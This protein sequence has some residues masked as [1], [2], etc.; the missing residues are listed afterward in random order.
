M[1]NTTLPALLPYAAKF[2]KE[3]DENVIPFWLKHSV[4]RKCGGY[5]SCLDR[6]GSVY[7][8]R[9]YMWLQGR[10]VWMFARL[11][12]QWEKKPEYLDAAKVGADFLREKPFDARGR[13]WFSTDREGRPL[14]FQRKVYPGLFVC[15]GLLEYSIATGD[16]AFRRQATDLFWKIHAWLDDPSLIERPPLAGQV[17]MSNLANAMTRASL[18]IEFSQVDPDPRFRAVLRDCIPAIVRHYDPKL[19]VF[20]ENVAVDGRDLS[21][22]PEGRL[23]NPG[24]SIEVAWFLLE[25]LRFHPDATAREVALH[26]VEGSLDVGWDKE[27]GGMFYFMDLEGK[28]LL[29]LESTMKLW[30]PHTEAMIALVFAA[31]ETGEAR[32]TKWLEKVVDYTWAHYPDPKHG[33]WFGY[34]DREGRLTHACKGNNYKGFFHVPRALMMCAQRIEAAANR[35]S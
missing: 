33:H 17:P 20:R 22:L 29:Q 10:L 30:W 31:T 4:D 14:F 35:K 5:F 23:F 16:A 6:E 1:K 15:L 24:H 28:P 7:D 11:W 9:K 3:L 19:R 18:A 25:L 2:R 26:A 32:W 8:D 27:F 21:A 12:N 34:C 13:V